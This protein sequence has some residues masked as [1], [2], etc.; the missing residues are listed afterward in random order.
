MPLRSRRRRRE[1]SPFPARGS[2]TRT[3][4]GA[5]LGLGRRHLLSRQTRPNGDPERG[6]H[7]SQDRARPP[8][9]G[10][11]HKLSIDPSYVTAQTPRWATSQKRVVFA[12]EQPRA[13]AL[14]SPCRLA[15]ARARPI[16]RSVEASDQR[17]SQMLTVAAA[18]HGSSSGR[19]G[20]LGAT[21]PRRS[22]SL[23]RSTRRRL[24]WLGGVGRRA[25]AVR[26]CRA[27]VSS[28]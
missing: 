11:A 8:S 2:S 6:R 14:P 28:L 16:A 5:V 19:T 13:Q 15:T 3:V 1:H 12:H 21:P 27:A 20:G 22:R 25:G 23:S 24:V 26:R 17:C 18:S 4:I 10:F 9:A 7:A